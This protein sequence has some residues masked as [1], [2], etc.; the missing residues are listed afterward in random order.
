[1]LTWSLAGWAGTLRAEDVMDGYVLDS[2]FETGWEPVQLISAKAGW[3]LVS[4]TVCWASHVTSYVDK[5]SPKPLPHLLC[6]PA[7]DWS[8]SFP[9]AIALW[10]FCSCIKPSPAS[11]PCPL[12]PKACSCCLLHLRSHPLENTA[13]K[14]LLECVP[15]LAL[16]ISCQSPGIGRHW[17]GTYYFCPHLHHLPLFPF[18]YPRSWFVSISVIPARSRS[19]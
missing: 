7:S 9:L 10:P 15:A 14:P 16:V 6:L 17:D 13:L 19:N 8:L 11:C 1:M 4:V 5:A 3:D 12:F 2:G 18:P